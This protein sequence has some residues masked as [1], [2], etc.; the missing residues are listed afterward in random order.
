MR[1]DMGKYEVPA[2]LDM[3][4][5]DDGA[6][7]VLMV[8]GGSDSTALAYLVSE[9][10]GARGSDAPCAIF[11]VNHQLRGADA[12]ADE[13]FVAALADGLG[14]PVVSERIDVAAEA[15]AN[16]ENVEAC[17]RRIRYEHAARALAELGGGE[18]LGHLLV[19]HTLDDRVENFY[20]RSIVG[21]G[22]G[23]FRAM[24]RVSG[25][26]VRPLL[27]VSRD[28]LRAYIEARAARGAFVARTAHG[29]LWCEDATNADT[30]GFRAF[31]RHE[32]VP[33]AKERNPKLLET[34]ERTMDLIADE[35]D[36]LAELAVDARRETLTW[37]DADEP[38]QGFVL[39]PAF[40]QLSDVLA[41]RVVFAA[42]GE[43]LGTDA[44]VET[45]SVE[46]VLAAIA[47]GKLQ[48]GYVN[49]IQGNLAVSSNKRGIRVEPMAAFRTRRKRSGA[50]G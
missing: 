34:L 22:P 49:N 13:A 27:S 10:L 25:L 39:A 14:L 6:S 3:R 24:K 23:G 42:L 41:R 1:K 7:L 9:Y 47:N 26:I 17:A 46:A 2:L 18:G 35:D 33:K 20:M 45:A 15:A 29:A 16:K 5:A 11:H 8:S 19:A 48:S 37:L 32:I 50:Q 38:T 43:V 36:Y 28:D 31:V 30:D 12:D 40:A 21:T 44:R 4:G